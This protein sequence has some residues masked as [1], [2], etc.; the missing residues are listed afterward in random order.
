MAYECN[1]VFVSSR[2]VRILVLLALIGSCI[3]QVNCLN[4]SF[5]S[6]K[7]ED[8]DVLNFSANSYIALGALQ[9]T[10]DVNG[11]SNTSGRVLYGQPFRLSNGQLK[12]S[13]ISSFV[14]NI[15]PQTSPT[16]EGLA[17]ILTESPPLPENSGGQW[18]GIINSSTTGSS[19]IVAVE[20][21]TRKSFPEDLD[22]NHVG[23]D[24]RSTVSIAQASL[25][26]KG[27]N[28]SGGYDIR[29][30]LFYDAE[31]ATI[32]I[33]VYRGEPRAED[34][35]LSHPLDLYEY[36]GGD[37]YV[38]FSASTGVNATQL[39]CVKS[40]DFISY[41]KS[42]Q[43]PDKTSFNPLWIWLM[44]SVS[45]VTLLILVILFIRY[46]KRSHERRL[47]EADDSEVE[48]KILNSSTAPQKFRLKELRFATENFNSM[49]KL[50]KGGFGTVYKGVLGDN[51]V[52]VKRI[53]KNSS[54]GK[55]DFIAEVTSI[56]NLH[57]KNLVKLIGWCYEGNELLLVYEFMPNGSLDKFIFRNETAESEDDKTLTW[58][59][60]HNI[61]IGVAQALDYLHNGC[62]NRVLHRDINASNILMDLE[63][64]ARLGDFGLARVIQLNE[65]T[66][67]STKE[68]AGTP[69]YMAPESF[70]TGRATVETDVY[71]FGILMLE[72]V[73]GR[74][75]GQQCEANGY[76]NSIVDWVWENYRINNLASV[77][78][79]RINEDA[80]M[81]QI[82]NVLMLA[83]SCC[84]PNPYERPPMNAALQVLSGEAEP[85]EVAVEKP[86]FMWPV[87][88]PLREVRC[89][90]SGA[91]LTASALL[92]GR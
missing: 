75:P 34:P 24:V 28:L 47:M 22:D 13:F 73:C 48:L 67:H 3:V 86:A 10:P 42:V 25:N 36:L 90:Q 26:D 55:K 38:G 84:H 8:R 92:S 29:A 74:R 54:H 16:G 14:F 70:H 44:V 33:V 21:D 72:I 46:K 17:F 20:F 51:V 83:L 2:A 50:G 31:L 68:I 40:W 79:S 82:K 78:D 41:E 12:T 60:R 76:C 91:Q 19:N 88:G 61:I 9:V 71:A 69:G 62:Q 45:V 85:A 30:T 87:F 58:G 59:R 15:Q 6:F 37:I 49:N 32:D 66:H 81:E 27:L 1:N 77:V 56:G 57:H 43:I 18:I 89:S 53:S 65:N 23:I 7:P 64:N 35:V 4:I 5:P 63:F 80:D 52:A 39:N 11:T